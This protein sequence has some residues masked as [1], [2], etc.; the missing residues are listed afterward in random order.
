MKIR[1]LMLP[2]LLFTLSAQASDVKSWAWGVG[3]GA[4]SAVESNFSFDVKTPWLWG[5]DVLG[6]LVLNVNS[7]RTT[8]QQAVT[9]NEYN[10]LPVRLLVEL[11]R[12]LYKEVISGYTR[13]GAGYN[14]T[15]KTIHSDGGWSTIPVQFG[16]DVIIGE[17]EGETISSFFIQTGFDFAFDVNRDE[18]ADDLN[19]VE[20]TLGV[21]RF[22]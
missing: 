18:P 20:I 13:I 16:A 5:E 6:S 14:F 2:L 11:R 8:F 3:F 17:N 15:D 10:V 4:K 1:F 12:P 22:Y 21:R 9:N 19:G 7:Q